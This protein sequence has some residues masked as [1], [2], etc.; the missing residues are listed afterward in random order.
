[1]KLGIPIMMTFICIRIL[2]SSMNGREGGLI[3]HNIFLPKE[4]ET[5]FLWAWMYYAR[6][7]NFSIICDLLIRRKVCNILALFHKYDC[8]PHQF[9]L[10]SGLWRL[11]IYSPELENGALEPKP[12]LEGGSDGVYQRIVGTDEGE[13][14]QWQTIHFNMVPWQC[15]DVNSFGVILMCIR[16][17]IASTTNA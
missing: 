7:L 17:N 11:L 12:R 15:T 14:L 1:M 2:M 9:S 16:I 4:L 5:T 10:E 13:M 3:E 8:L 6:N